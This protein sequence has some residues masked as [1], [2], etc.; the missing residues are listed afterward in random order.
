MIAYVVTEGQFN[1]D[2]LRTLLRPE[3]VQGVGFVRAGGVSAIRS[4]A[5]SLVVVRQVPVAIVVDSDSMDPVVIR[6][7]HRDIE[8]FVASDSPGIP[9]KVIMAVPELEAIFFDDPRILDRIFNGGVTQGILDLARTEP[10]RA[11]R[12]YLQD[13]SR[14]RDLTI[15]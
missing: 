9:I 5:S 2:V 14:S 6:E 15:Y 10:H 12:I 11:C 13:R 8:E 4:M 1:A 3:L 7:R